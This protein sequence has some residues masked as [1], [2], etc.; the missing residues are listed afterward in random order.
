MRRKNVVVGTLLITLILVAAVFAE[1]FS[2]HNP[3]AL[4]VNNRLMAPNE[5]YLFGTDSQ[6]RDVYSRVIHGAR[7]S[8]G[9]GFAVATLTLLAGTIMGLL[10]GYD[11]RVDTVVGRLLDAMMAF[12]NIVLAIGVMAVRGSDILNVILALSIVSVPRLARVVRSV[13]MSI[14]ETQYVEAA[15]ATGSSGFR[16]LSRHILP[17][18]FSPL[19]VQVSF[20]FA[21]AVLGEAS[22]SFLGAGA[23]PEIPSWGGMLNDSRGVLR[24]APWTVLFPGA[25]ITLSVLALNLVGDGLRD[26]F[27]P[28]LRGR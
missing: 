9:V 12:P 20:V 22:L 13:V 5:T 15:R 6:G 28:Q 17:N 10:S 4:N 1:R 21:Q 27:D 2:T 18:C 26:W 16:I 11:R 8:L 24:Q 14:R 25:A 7:L 19:I 3:V 23:P